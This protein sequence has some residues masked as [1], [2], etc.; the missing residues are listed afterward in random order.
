[1]PSGMERLRAF[2]SPR[3]PGPRIGRRAAPD[4]SQEAQVLKQLV[5]VLP[6]PVSCLAGWLWTDR[7]SANTLVLF[8]SCQ[9]GQQPR[10]TCQLSG[11]RK[12]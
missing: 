6:Y 11:A 4:V 5:S 7:L 9:K 3:L 8:A 1:M 12:L 10:C 2:G